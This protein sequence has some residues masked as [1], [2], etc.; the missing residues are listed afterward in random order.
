MDR[1]RALLDSFSNI[2][3]D[4]DSFQYFETHGGKALESFAI[5]PLEAGTPTRAYD[6]TSRPSAK[7]QSELEKHRTCTL[8][9]FEA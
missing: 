9:K 4:S 7:R 5:H 1:N 2:V 6:G 3:T 8:V